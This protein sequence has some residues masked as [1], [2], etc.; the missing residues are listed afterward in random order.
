MGGWWVVVGGGWWPIR[1]YK[2]AQ[3]W[4]FWGLFGAFW[5][6][7]LWTG[8]WPRACQLRLLNNLISKTGFCCFTAF[9]ACVSTQLYYLD[10]HKHYY[11]RVVFP[12]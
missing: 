3:I 10:H 7:G 2:R 11:C 9:L 6:F 1:A 5:G 8:L 4:P 12:E